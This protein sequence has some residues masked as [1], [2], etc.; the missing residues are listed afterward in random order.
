MKLKV[1]FHLLITLVYVSQNLRADAFHPVISNYI[2]SDYGGGFQNWDVAQDDAGRIYVGN[3][4]GL[5][6]FDGFSW[7]LF[8]LPGNNIVRSVYYDDGKIYVGSF[9]KFGYYERNEKGDLDYYSL[10]DGL[11]DNDNMMKNEEVWRIM[12]WNGKI[13]FQTFNNIYSFDPADGS[14]RQMNNKIIGKDEEGDGILRPLFCY[15]ADENLYAQRINGSFYKL[16]HS[17]WKRLWRDELN[18]SYVMGLS[19]PDKIDKNKGDLPD[20]TLLFTQDSYIFEITNGIPSGI[21]TEIDNDLKETQIN[22]VLEMKDGS[23]FI[24]T[25]GK[26][27]F[28]IARNGKLLERYDI[29]CGLNNNTVLALKSDRQGN[30]WVALDD[31]LSLIHSGLPVK[32]MTPVSMSE[33]YGVGT[34]YSIGMKDG[35]FIIVSNQGAF[36]QKKDNDFQLIEGTKG[37]NWFVETFDRQTFVGG[38]DATII[39][40]ETGQA[41]SL[42]FSGTDII[43]ATI[44]GKEIL[45]QS[46][47][48]SLE[49]YKKNADGK[50]RYSH[51]IN[52][53]ETPIR[54][55]EVDNDGTVWASHWT[56]GVMQFRLSPELDKVTSKKFYPNIAGDSIPVKCHVMKVRGHTVFSSHKGLYEYDEENDDFKLSDKYGIL[57]SLDNL[58]YVKM[59][60]DNRF[61]IA[62]TNSYFLVSYD[63]KDYLIEYSVPLD[64]YPRKNNDDNSWVFIEDDTA[65]FTSNSVIGSVNMKNIRRPEQIYPLSVNYIGSYDRYGKFEKLP[66]LEGEKTELSNDNLTVVMSYPSFNGDTYKF[67]FLMTDG[68]HL[69]DSISSTP[70]MQYPELSWGRHEFKCEVIDENN[71]I[72]AEK[73][74]EFEIEKP[75]QLSWYA[76][77]GYG[78]ILM[79]FA[80]LM[81]RHVTSRKM[82]KK[83]LEF[84]KAEAEQ[85]RRIQEQELIIANQQKR[86]LESELSEKSKELASMA[87]GAFGRRQAIENMRASMADLKRKGGNV[88]EAEKVMNEFTKNDG[89]TRVF[90]DVFEKN[91]DLIHEHFFRNLR[92]VYPQL[93]P[94]DLKFCALL[95]MNMTTKEISR[96]T[97]LSIRGVETARYRL[98]KKFSLTKEQDLVQFLMEFHI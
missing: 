5:L 74:I 31:G 15:S 41:E 80:V 88:D 21:K 70:M 19:L 82:K 90:W 67:H 17:G 84:E 49:I 29:S 23:L 79:G 26:G 52:G 11:K 57:N 48:F 72:L 54:Q 50:W 33:G 69:L 97:N 2:D 51:S 1:I 91:F 14:L 43:K 78:V 96:F 98:R 95:R 37:Q 55:V 76:L 53:V 61:W 36:N 63:G 59:V 25:I 13:L 35:K 9:E 34:G 93:T 65:Y 16:T 75:W 28:H 39:I 46:T 89:D 56:N 6:C 30:V 87:L 62:G 64:L 94:S 3:G 85:N 12:P 68:S 4:D 81:S 44:H 71:H 32:L 40:D 73:I 92:K 7:E 58:N 24:G 38:N 86:L 18:G 66:L 42:P 27:V 83:Q 47:Y 10:S 22:R 77:A 60:D 8:P 20:G 45:L